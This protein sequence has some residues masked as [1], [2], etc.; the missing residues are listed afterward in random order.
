MLPLKFDKVDHGLGKLG[1]GIQSATFTPQVIHLNH[2]RIKFTPNER[3][4][5]MHRTLLFPF[6]FAFMRQERYS[7]FKVDTILDV[8]GSSSSNRSK[9]NGLKKPNVES[10]QVLDRTQRPYHTDSP[11]NGVANDRDLPTG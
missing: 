6:Q 5:V 3:L 10:S 8:L 11:P 2:H 7:L 1:L 4:E 9:F